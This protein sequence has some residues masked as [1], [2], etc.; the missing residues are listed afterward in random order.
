VIL[1][2]PSIGY[3]ERQIR[4]TTARVQRNRCDVER[5]RMRTFEKVAKNEP[6]RS[7]VSLLLF[8]RRGIPSNNSYR[9]EL[10]SVSIQFVMKC[11]RARNESTLFRPFPFTRN[12]SA[13]RR[14]CQTRLNTSYLPHRAI[15]YDLRLILA[16]QGSISSFHQDT[17]VLPRQLLRG[18]SEDWQRMLI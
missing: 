8:A 17:L 9:S 4:W 10:Q 13:P 7:V 2:P 5:S 12:D 6:L 15:Q 14:T 1:F 16:L 11:R 3:G 18:S